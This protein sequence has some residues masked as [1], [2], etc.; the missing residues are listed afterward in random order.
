MSKKEEFNDARASRSIL[1]SLGRFRDLANGEGKITEGTLRNCGRVLEV[2][3]IRSDCENHTFEK[4]AC[5]RRQWTWTQ[6]SKSWIETTFHYDNSDITIIFMFYYVK[7][8]TIGLLL[9]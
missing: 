7:F 3:F 5:H 1:T 2:T 9:Q 6:S 4:N 8:Y